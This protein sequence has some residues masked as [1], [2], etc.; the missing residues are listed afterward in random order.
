MSFSVSSGQHE[1]SQLS[2]NWRTAAAAEHSVNQREG[3]GSPR[4]D[5]AAPLGNTPRAVTA[6]SELLVFWF[7]GELQAL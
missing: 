7:S 6:L 3:A 5:A 1:L 2:S 4:P